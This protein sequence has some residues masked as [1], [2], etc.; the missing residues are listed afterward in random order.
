[1]QFVLGKQIDSKWTF[2]PLSLNLAKNNKTLIIWVL[3]LHISTKISILHTEIKNLSEL[4]HT[5]STI[6][7]QML[8]IMN[9]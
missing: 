7:F 5:T 2:F 4:I 3:I 9:L 1:M 6:F 8:E